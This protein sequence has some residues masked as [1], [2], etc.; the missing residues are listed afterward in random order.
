MGGQL[1]AGEIN[2]RTI[3]DATNKVW[4]G[5]RK[6]GVWTMEWTLL[7]KTMLE[8]RLSKKNILIIN[9]KKLVVAM[10]YRFLQFNE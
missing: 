7:S 9:Q 6:S 1:Y 10:I 5:K 8:A 2:W 3:Y 4:S